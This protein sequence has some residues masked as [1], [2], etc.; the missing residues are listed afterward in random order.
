MWAEPSTFIND[1]E[2]ISLAN[3]ARMINTYPVTIK[4]GFTNNGM[5]HL[6]IERPYTHT[7][8]ARVST[9]ITLES[10]QWYLITVQK[11]YKQAAEEAIAE[12][13]SKAAAAIKKKQKKDDDEEDVLPPLR[14][15]RAAR[16]KRA[17]AAVVSASPPLRGGGG[18]GIDIPPQWWKN[19]ESEIYSMT[20]PATFTGVLNSDQLKERFNIAIEKHVKRKIDSAFDAD[21]EATDMLPVIRKR[22]YES[23]AI[24]DRVLSE[25]A[26]RCA[27][28]KIR[29]FET[30]DVK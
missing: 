22:L 5:T 29:P 26:T 7:G 12:V 1:G 3:A 18:G 8:K 27:W 19:L 13:R 9:F 23:V 15:A 4:N 21:K 17:T 11:W 10:F 28:E 30:A 14:A 2:Y 25:V 16:P 6:L 24:K 20:N